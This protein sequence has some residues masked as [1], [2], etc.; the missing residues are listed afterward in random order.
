MQ[1]PQNM[2]GDIEPAH[3]GARQQDMCDGVRLHQS[4]LICRQGAMQ[5]GLTLLCASHRSGVPPAV[6]C[7]APPWLHT[8]GSSTLGPVTHHRLCRQ[9]LNISGLAIKL[10]GPHNICSSIQAQKLD[11]SHAEEPFML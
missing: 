4:T 5:Q 9:A 3:T 7:T 1:L 6:A 8:L 11:A 10:D 2:P